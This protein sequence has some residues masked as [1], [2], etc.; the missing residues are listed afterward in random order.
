MIDFVDTSLFLRITFWVAIE[1]HAPC[2]FIYPK[3]V[4]FAGLIVFAL[5]SRVIDMHMRKHI[6][7]VRSCVY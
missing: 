6:I 3:N 2:I 7:N 5:G 4:Y 1:N